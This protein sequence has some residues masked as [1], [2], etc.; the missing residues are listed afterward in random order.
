MPFLVYMTPYQ[1]D[2]VSSTGPIAG[3]FVPWG[4]FWG[5]YALILAL[6][7]QIGGSM[8]GLPPQTSP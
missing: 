4:G 1:D 2:S 7:E 5:S 8:G 6:Q 3:F